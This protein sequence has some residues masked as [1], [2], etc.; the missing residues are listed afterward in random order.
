MKLHHCHIGAWT[1]Y[2]I[3]LFCIKS[4]L[5]DAT[6]GFLYCDK[7][8]VR[9]PLVFLGT[10]LSLVSIFVLGSG[11]GRSL[12]C[13]WKIQ[14]MD[15]LLFGWQRSSLNIIVHICPF[16]IGSLVELLYSQNIF[17]PYVCNIAS[18][19]KVI[20]KNTEKLKS[21]FTVLV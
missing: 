14:V 5:D 8:L 20:I 11:F 4:Y 21:T 16:S 18:I 10:L 12:F 15:V 17:L 2:E 13:I 19:S 7:I 1:I 3:F 6:Y 9:Q